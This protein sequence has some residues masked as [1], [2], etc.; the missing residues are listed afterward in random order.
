M[1]Q[2]LPPGKSF[3]TALE[4]DIFNDAFPKLDIKIKRQMRSSTN[5]LTPAVQRG[6]QLRTKPVGFLTVRVGEMNI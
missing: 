4:E 3:K 2:A 5:C 1:K 6:S